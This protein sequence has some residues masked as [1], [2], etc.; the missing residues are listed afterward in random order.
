MSSFPIHTIESAPEE[1]RETLRH[2]KQSIGMIP[3]LAAGM[4]EAPSLLRAFFAARDAYIGGTL[5][6]VEIQVLSLANAFENGC[7]WCMAFHSAGA[8]KD[9]LSKEALEDLRAGRDPDDAR[10]GALSRLSRALIRNRGEVREEELEAFY[11]AGFGRAQALEVVLGIGFSTM[12]NYAGH[13]V[14]APLGGMLEPY[15][16]SRP[17][18]GA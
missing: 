8:L 18:V 17:A 2:V 13:L 11:A 3:N 1:A 10:L 12:A 4:A 15:A 5:R 6:P 16:W 7:E 14:Q 9:G